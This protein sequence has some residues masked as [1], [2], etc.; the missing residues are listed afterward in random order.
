MS[1]LFSIFFLINTT[2]APK[3]INADIPTPN[4]TK[5]FKFAP[6]F[7]DGINVSAGSSSGSS[8]PVPGTW[9]PGVDGGSEPPGLSISTISTSLSNVTSLVLDS[10][11]D[12]IRSFDVC[13]P[14]FNAVAKSSV[15]R[16]VL[17][18]AFSLSYT[19]L[20]NKSFNYSCVFS[21]QP[22]FRLSS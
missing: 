21:C 20:E 1:Y 18:W 14:A 22:G 9:F 5:K 13:S 4:G 6:V 8:F 15:Y 11:T 17:F 12:V 7:V 19:T 2:P 16:I 3:I 10:I